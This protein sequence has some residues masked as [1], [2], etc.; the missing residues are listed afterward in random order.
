[1]RMSHFFW[2]NKEK[3]GRHYES[4]SAQKL[5]RSDRV[6]QL[7]ERMVKGM[8]RYGAVSDT[9]KEIYVFGIYQTMISGLEIL[10]MLVTGILC[11]VGW[12]CVIFLVSF[13]VLRRYAGGYHASTLPRCVLMS[14][15][16]VF[17]ACMW[18]KFVL[19]DI[20][21]QSLLLLLTGLVIFIFAP[22]Q[23]RHKKLYDYEIKKYWRY[24]VIIW[25][26]YVVIYIILWICNYD[27]CAQCIVIGNTM[28]SFVI[29]MTVPWKKANNILG[30]KREI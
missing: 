22:V 24:S 20:W 27:S 7:A 4:E 29:G 25:S 8:I 10:L 28:V 19:F 21:I 18:A 11:G 1:M 13:V 9:D 12:Q 15:S 14:W 16:I 2:Q 26:I 30:K 23:D 5:C 3:E 17:G 6:K